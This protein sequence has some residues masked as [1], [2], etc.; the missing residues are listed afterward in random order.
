MTIQ[1]ELQGRKGDMNAARVVTPIVLAMG[2]GIYNFIRLGIDPA[3]YLYTYVPLFGGMAATFGFLTWYFRVSK[4]LKVSWSNLLILLGMI[5][6]AYF[7]YAIAFIGLY[8]VYRGIVGWSIWLV[9]GGVVWTSVLYHG[10]Y[11][12]WVMTEMVKERDK[13]IEWQ[14]DR[15]GRGGPVEATAV[16]ARREKDSPRRVEKDSL[17]GQRTQRWPEGE[18]VGGLQ[19]LPADAL[20][21]LIDYS[22]LQED[23]PDCVIDTSWLPADKEKMKDVLKLS[24][25]HATNDT[26]RDWVATGW[27]LLSHFQDGVG[28]IPIPVY[29]KTPKNLPINRLIDHAD[30]QGRWFD[31]M[32][33][34]G[35]L[36][37]REFD[38]FKQAVALKAHSQN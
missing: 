19:T 8:M 21:I 34:D 28:Q 14:K 22:A 23:F 30:E 4:P 1:D 31:R 3:Q 7:V 33:A 6:Y 15:D 11:M 25:L 5:P 10:I 17:R 2:Y 20:Q 35:E 36:L 29:R 27:Y 32:F 37:A 9:I 16:V 38:E 18:L 12:F 26:A 13:Q 24:W